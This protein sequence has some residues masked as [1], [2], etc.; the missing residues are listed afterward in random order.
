MS[1]ILLNQSVVHYE[2]LGRGRPVLFLHTWVGSWRYWVPCLQVSRRISQRL[3]SGS[4]RIRRHGPRRRGLL[5]RAARRALVRFLP[6]RDG[7]R[8][9]RPGGARPRRPRRPP[10]RRLAPGPCRAHSGVSRPFDRGR[11]TAGASRPDAS[12]RNC[13]TSLDRQ[14]CMC[15]PSCCPK[16]AAIDP[17]RAASFPSIRRSVQRCLLRRS[18][19]LDR[20][21]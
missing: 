13:S 17:E 15:E 6:G 8:P 2:S 18:K 19:T 21:R 14:G 7:H 4:L 10:L 16:H 3:R 11:E 12:D 5:A 9:H 20:L 1:V